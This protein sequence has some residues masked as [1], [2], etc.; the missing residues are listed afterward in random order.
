MKKSWSALD[1][2]LKENNSLNE[3]IIREI[4][5]RKATKSLN[6]LIFWD[7]IS[8][9]VFLAIIPICI[10]WMVNNHGKFVFGDITIIYALIFCILGIFWFIYKIRRLLNVD[11]NG[12]I[13]N[14]ILYINKY[15]I[16]F[17]REKIFTGILS[18]LAPILI[19]LAY[20]EMKVSLNIWTLMISALVFA[21]IASYYIYAKIYPK[22]INTIR[23]S[24]DE[25]KD[26]KEV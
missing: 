17:K 4:L 2:R 20:I 15:K 7:G 13:N 24:L 26:L 14:N 5:E 18:V 10:Y 6:R 9:V 8:I 12:K 1:E 22:N 16:D 23:N 19:V 11:I 25:I 3:R 21:C